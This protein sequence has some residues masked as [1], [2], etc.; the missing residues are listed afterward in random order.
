MKRLSDLWFSLL[1]I[2]AITCLVLMVILVFGNVVLRY[3]FNSGI[4]FSEEASRLLFIYITFLG[5]AIALREHLHLGID[6]VVSRLNPKQRRTCLVLSQLLM[7]YVTWLLLIGS[8]EQAS[9][10][11]AT[12]TPVI[13]L[14]MA[15]VY[16]VGVLFSVTTGGL[17]LCS[18]I[19]SLT[20]KMDDR[21]VSLAVGTL[22][23]E[24][25]PLPPS[26]PA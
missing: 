10:N 16:G 2:T 7:L 26:T 1:K 3:L 21:E 4:T 17:L 20:G 6:S 19:R 11:L 13:G 22:P 5:A 15:A 23:P 14:S 12:L 18:L 9:I 8:W 25:N 24:Q